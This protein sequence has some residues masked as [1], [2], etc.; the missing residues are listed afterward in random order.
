MKYIKMMARAIGLKIIYNRLQDFLLKQHGFNLLNRAKSIDF[1]SPYEVKEISGNR[2]LLPQIVNAA[3]SEKIIFLEKESITDKVYV[4]DYQGIGKNAWVS[5][6]GSVIIE[7][8]VIPIDWN[9]NSFYKD[10][11][12]RDERT[13]K[14]AP[15]MIALFSQ[16]QDGI[17][18]GGYYDFVFLVA[19]K[20]S[21][22]KDALPNE[23]L[24]E[25]VISYP[26][27]NAAYETDYLKL[28]GFKTDNLID[29]RVCKVITPRL[30]T[31]NS[32]HWHPN[33]EDILSLKRHIGKNFKPTKTASS[34]I[35]I[36]RSGRRCITNEDELI[37]L[38][39]KFHFLIIEDKERTITEQI[40]IYHNASIILGP[41]GA[42]FSNIIWCQPGT[43]L[44]EL[45]SPN[46]A[47]DF[48]LYL[49]TIME[50]KYSAYFEGSADSKVNYLDGL[51][52]DISISIPKLEICL[53]NIFRTES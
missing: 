51:V 37:L 16:F 13:V 27:F 7:R 50:M 20:L 23:D 41:H 44:F 39:K 25:M 24:S 6:Y 45:F 40:S 53:E 14:T 22:I 1:M 11:W 9:H 49:A 18:Y 30:I 35:Y 42:S 15:A 19:T 34:R 46:Y 32:A 26:L 48:F 10:I 36:S 5:K 33:L 43:H 17:F 47:P 21:R 52:E 38:L 4:W 2:A 8:K 29:S 31:G 3:D 12:K 28:L